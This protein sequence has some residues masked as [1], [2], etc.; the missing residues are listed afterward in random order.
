[1]YSIFY[2]CITFS[3]LFVIFNKRYN[4]YIQ[5]LYLFIIINIILIFF[6]L[7]DITAD[8]FYYN[9]I[10]LHDYFLG[11][12]R[13][14]YDTF[15]YYFAH[16]I[17]LFQN[18]KIADYL[19]CF[20]FIYSL[21]FFSKKFINPVH[22][23]IMFFP[24]TLVAIMQGFPRQAWALMLIIIACNLIFYL[25]EK[26][27]NKSSNQE[28]LKIYIF[29]IMLF[30]VFFH[31][32]AILFFFIYVFYLITLLNRKLIFLSFCL[33]LF[34]IAAL[35]YKFNIFHVFFEKLRLMSD[36]LSTREEDYSIKGFISRFTIIFFP[37][38]L[39]LVNYF[40]NFK[41]KKII[42]SPIDK[43]FVLSSIFYI[44]FSLFTLIFQNYLLVLDRLNIY[45]F[46]ITIYFFGRFI[47]FS[48]FSKKIQKLLIFV[49]II[50][51][52][53]Y[54]ILWVLYSRS[55]YE[56]KYNFSLF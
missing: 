52:N 51:L 37:A 17:S 46:L 24:Y 18:K 3:S 34:I 49:S 21:Y 2:L 15:F 8:S 30:S 54:L 42:F 23:V 6:L 41:N 50:Y 5:N 32:S 35:H 13:Q 48:F 29:L 11:F 20:L 27:Q 40:K 36:F 45:F 39:I 38:L 10:F 22:I 4:K 44:F 26:K 53:F 56:F 33:I 31:Y 19:L 43:F 55:Y 1:M 47:F 14:G 9:S 25:T 16:L 12:Q 7:N 28:I